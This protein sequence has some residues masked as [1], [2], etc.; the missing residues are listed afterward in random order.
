MI[1]DHS[2]LTSSFEKPVAFRAPTSFLLNCPDHE[3]VKSLPEIQRE[4]RFAQMVRTGR[5]G[6][7]GGPWSRAIASFWGFLGE[8]CLFGYMLLNIFYEVMD[9]L[10][11]PQE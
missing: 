8:F 9:E 10:L 6:S 11:Y 4:K 2:I 1:L 7:N 5:F 3:V